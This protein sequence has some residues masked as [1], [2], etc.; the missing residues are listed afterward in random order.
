MAFD[1]VLDFALC[2]VVAL[3]VIVNSSHVHLISIQ[4]KADTC[5]R[6]LGLVNP[7]LLFGSLLPNPQGAV[8]A[9]AG[10]EISG[11][12]GTG[13][14]LDHTVMPPILP[15]HLGSFEIPVADRFV[16]GTGNQAVSVRPGKS[17]HCVAVRF[18]VEDV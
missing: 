15:H 11:L 12:L 13:Y 17:C 1:N 5:Y 7:E 14:V 2:D 4:T 6:V 3:Y 9:D 8:I 16:G 10:D 18:Q